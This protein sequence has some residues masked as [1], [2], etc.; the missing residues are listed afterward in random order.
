MGL[1]KAVWRLLKSSSGLIFRKKIRF[2][3]LI[4]QQ[5]SRDHL[6]QAK[7]SHADVFDDLAVS[8]IAE[9]SIFCQLAFS[10]CRMDKPEVKWSFINLKLFEIATCSSDPLTFQSALVFKKPTKVAYLNCSQ[11][12][13]MGYSDIP[14]KGQSE[15]LCKIKETPL[16]RELK[17]TLGTKSFVL[18]D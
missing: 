15:T 17:P 18:L 4:L 1:L 2:Q 5:G 8:L 3:R 7:P 14:A 12:K 9:I 10:L 11:L 13:I 16:M 6:P